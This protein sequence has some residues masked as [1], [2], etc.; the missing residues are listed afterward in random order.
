MATRQ[1]LSE[2]QR[3]P[4]HFHLSRPLTIIKENAINFVNSINRF[5]CAMVKRCVVFEAR[6][7]S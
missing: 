5:M 2:V 4:G 3:G 6:I 1:G 7:D